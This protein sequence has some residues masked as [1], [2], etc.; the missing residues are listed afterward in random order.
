MKKSTVLLATTNPGKRQ[1][2]LSALL[3]LEKIEFVT[4]D[5][6]GIRADVSETGQSYGE[7][8]LIKAREYFRLSGIPTIAE[9]SGV[10]VSALRGELGVNTRYWGAGAEATDQEWLQHFMDRMRHESDRSARFV[11]HAV[12]ISSMGHWNIEGE[13]LGTIT[14][15]VAGP[16]QKGIPMSAVF[17]PIGADLVYSAMSEEEKNQLS[18]RGKAMKQLRE[19]LL[20]NL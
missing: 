15:D 4:L 16:I 20:Q 18:H 3:P 6:L 2:I 14:H 13:C 1:E 9:D 11:C 19:Y 10:E 5:D 12:Y 17:Q 8:A 7:N